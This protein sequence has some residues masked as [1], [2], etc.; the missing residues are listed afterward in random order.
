[1]PATLIG[2]MTAARPV[3]GKRH[4]RTAVKYTTWR[5]GVKSQEPFLH[6]TDIREAHT[7]PAIRK[8]S[9]HVVIFKSAQFKMVSV[10]HAEHATFRLWLAVNYTWKI[11]TPS[12]LVISRVFRN[13]HSD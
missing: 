1:M 7:D 5:K 8:I 12:L 2:F 9:L 6:R 4:P 13:V 11:K 3:A 10:E